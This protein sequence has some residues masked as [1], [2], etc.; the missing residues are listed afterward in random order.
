MPC[1]RAE[2]PLP[3]PCVSP[4]AGPAAGRRLSRCPSWATIS[5]LTG[6]ACRRARVQSRGREGRARRH[7][8]A[9]STGATSPEG[10]AMNVGIIGS[11]PG[12]ADA[13]RRRLLDA[14]GQAVMIS[15][16]DPDAPKDLGPRGVV[17]GRPTR[18]GDHQLRPGP[19]GGGGRAS[20]RPP[21]SASCS[22]NATAGTA[23]LASP[24]RPP[25]AADIE[26]KIT[27]RPLQ[28]ARLLAAACRR[29]LAFCNYDSLG[30]R[31]QAA[32]PSARV[33]KTLNTLT[34]P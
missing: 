2:R 28:P 26:G 1:A 23:S 17:A 14:S 12:G 13:R 24:R 33:V 29:G 5:P 21:P 15:A 16:R 30:E 34:S 3:E 6:V 20:P 31:L 27:A 7:E 19:R 8:P 25:T 10:A 4:P 9:R 18:L 22:V 32:Y 11:G